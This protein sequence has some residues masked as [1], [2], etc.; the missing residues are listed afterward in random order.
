VMVGL[1]LYNCSWGLG[2]EAM[3]AFGDLSFH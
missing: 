1:R 3:A 2:S